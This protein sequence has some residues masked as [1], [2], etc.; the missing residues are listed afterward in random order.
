MTNEEII[1]RYY[2]EGAEIGR[3]IRT[4]NSYPSLVQI[5]EPLITKERAKELFEREP[6]K[7]RLNLRRNNLDL[8]VVLSALGVDITMKRGEVI[9][10]VQKLVKE[11]DYK[12]SGEIM[13]EEPWLYHLIAGLGQ[14]EI[15]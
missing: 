9:L 15:F 7:N 3:T 10:S 8:Y 4:Q 6:L 11:R 14:E 13:R 12:S 1:R 2:H 5:V